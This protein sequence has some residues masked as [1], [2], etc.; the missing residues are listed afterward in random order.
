MMIV[1]WIDG[2]IGYRHVD[3]SAKLIFP[4]AS[5]ITALLLGIQPVSQH[6]FRL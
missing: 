5:F 3:T 2:K 1:V 6:S 4:L